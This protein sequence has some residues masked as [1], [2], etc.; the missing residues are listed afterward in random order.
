MVPN[1]CFISCLLLLIFTP[2]AFSVVV[3]D[4]TG[5]H[6]VDQ[7]CSDLISDPISGPISTTFTPQY[8]ANRDKLLND[9]VANTSL[10]DG[11]M[12]TSSKLGT[13]ESEYAYGHALCRHDVSP[14]HCNKC[15]A[16]ISATITASCSSEEAAIWHD[17]CLLAYS[18]Q[19]GSNTDDSTHLK[20]S[21]NTEYNV[22]FTDKMLGLFYTLVGEIAS[23]PEALMFATGNA[24]YGDGNSLTQCMSW[25]NAPR[26]SQ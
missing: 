9:L 10:N 18:N 8:A 21:G 25:S 24:T 17:H 4:N 11:F 7:T 13:N 16:I 1:G 19:K 2:T 5:D 3:D 6:Y 14:D 12:T 20:I 15:L 22:T 23:R 26:I